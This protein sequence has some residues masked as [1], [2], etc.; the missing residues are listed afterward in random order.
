MAKRALLTGATGFVGGHL[1]ER[2]AQEGWTSRAVVRPTS[3]TSLLD[4]L[5]LETVTTDLRDADGVARA[6]EGAEVVFHLAAATF[7]RREEEFWSANVDATR[8]V[9]EGAARAGSRAVYLSSYAACG[10]GSYDRPRR[11]GDEPEPLSAYGRTKLEGERAARE[12]AP[13]AVIVRAP[14]VYGPRDRALLPLFRMARLG[15]VPVPGGGDRPLHLLFAP[16][17]AGALVRAARVAAGT[18][19]VAGPGAPAWREVVSVVGDALGRRVLSVPL[20]PA[21]VR[22]AA[23]ATEGVARLLG[24]SA[25]FGRDKA[26]EMLA[27]GWLCDLSGSEALLPAGEATALAEGMQK[28]VAWYR[29][30]GWL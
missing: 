6:A 26:R 10:P 14:A 3:D 30:N 23:A 12:L 16:D 24:R 9:M 19:A 13:E 7:A 22:G 4:R 27:P 15:V 1:A 17:L 29:T 20:S 11:A 18:Y 8:A 28:T 25:T 21:L 2:L 5:S